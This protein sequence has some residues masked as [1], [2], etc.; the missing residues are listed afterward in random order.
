MRYILIISFLLI[1][2][3]CSNKPEYQIKG[4]IKSDFNG[5]VYLK[6][7]EDRSY[8]IIDSCT[9]TNG[10]FK[11]KGTV[12]L[13][14]MYSIWLDDQKR[15][16][17]FCLENAKYEMK[18]E[19]KISSA[20]ISGSV[21]Q[22]A[23]NTFTS[24][25][26]SIE[27]SERELISQLRSSWKDSTVLEETKE[28]LK[29]DLSALRKNKVQF[30]KDFVTEGTNNPYSLT[31]LNIYI[32]NFLTID[33]LDSTYQTLTAKVQKTTFGQRL[34][35][36]IEN[37][38]LSAVGQPY[39]D[40][41]VPNVDGN[42]I[43]LSE[44]VKDNKLVFVDFW[45]SWCAPCRASI[46]HLKELYTQY[47]D[48]GLEIVAVSYDS[49]RD[50]WIKAIDNEELEWLNGSNLQGWGCPTALQYAV[51]GIP[52]TVLISSDGKIVARNLR[53]NAL[54]NKI[55]EFLKEN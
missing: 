54:K 1:V 16:K 46:P 35:K 40:F 23:I 5:L 47:H 49:E 17:D 42:I 15:R 29:E 44:V 48:K 52:A 43:K 22:N 33:Q 21:L 6:K 11:F 50:S 31:V 12:E 18:I 24:G 28:K 10:T 3:A 7:F 9:V 34:A 2:A 41:E 38:R 27:Q 26:T 30:A 55:D 36:E 14:D 51:R 4:T 25:M 53:G 32:R 19:D 39:I 8:I 20:E 45:A 37:T 13:P